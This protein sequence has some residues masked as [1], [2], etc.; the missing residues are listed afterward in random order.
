MLPRGGD[1]PWE[2]LQRALRG[3]VDP[4]KFD[5]MCGT[6]S[7]AFQPGENRRIAVK[8]IDFRGNEVIRVVELDGTNY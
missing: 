3:T 8:V 2:K 5:A 7:A 1:N 6:V 4:E